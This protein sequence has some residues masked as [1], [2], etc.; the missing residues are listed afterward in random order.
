M[1]MYTNTSSFSSSR[2]QPWFVPC[3][4]GCASAL[5]LLAAVG[6]AVGADLAGGASQENPQPSPALQVEQAPQN[7]AMPFDAQRLGL[8]KPAKDLLGK[9]VIDP[10]SKT[11]GTLKDFILDLPSGQVM[12]ALVSSS[13]KNPLTPVPARSF[14]AVRRDKA[15][16]N[17]AKKLF[18]YAPRFPLASAAGP[19]DARSLADSF[20]HFNQT[21]PCPTSASFCSA[22]ALLGLQLVSS[23]N[24]VLGQV[25]ELA[26]DLPGARL[27]YLVIQ[28]AAGLDPLDNLYIVPPGSVVPG[29]FGQSLILSATRAS[30]LAGYHFP[31]E[32]PTDMVFPEVAAAVYQHYGLLPNSPDKPAASPA[33]ALPA[34][35]A[36]SAHAES[37][38]AAPNIQDLLQAALRAYDLTTVRP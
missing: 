37:N 17:A 11:L 1:L 16:L 15:E 31:K 19:W 21:A 2:Q 6:L 7:S 13:G 5:V 26:I 28:P 29:T 34:I 22:A 25:Q 9:K 10:N 23:T 30:F 32:F 35:D 14:E 36:K 18:E 38:S 4:R 3:R 24:E 27:V 12:A 33:P 20:A 8:I